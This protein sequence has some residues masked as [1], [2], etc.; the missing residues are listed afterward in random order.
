MMLEGTGEVQYHTGDDRYLELL[1]DTLSN[2]VRRR[3][4]ELILFQAGVDVL[5]SDKP[6]KLPLSREGIRLRNE[7]LF[8]L[9]WEVGA[10]KADL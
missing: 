9:A 8:E 4:P 6:G 3:R 2:V 7:R 10:A 1:D 5:A